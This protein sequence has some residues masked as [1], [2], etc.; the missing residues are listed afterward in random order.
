MQKNFN[1]FSSP[2]IIGA[3]MHHRL[4]LKPRLV[5]LL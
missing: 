5:H 4:Y 1:C 2:A 3:A